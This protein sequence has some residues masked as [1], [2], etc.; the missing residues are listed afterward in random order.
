MVQISKGQKEQDY[1][2]PPAIPKTILNEIEDGFKKLS[3]PEF[4]RKC[5]GGQTQNANES[6]NNILWNISPKTGWKG[7]LFLMSN[8]DIVPGKN[9]LSAAVIKGQL[10]IKEAEK[11]TEIN[12][13]KHED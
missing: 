11:Q 3:E 6:F 4:L 2:H 9:A 13:K 8:L 1:V 7:L 10:R 12:S 5:L